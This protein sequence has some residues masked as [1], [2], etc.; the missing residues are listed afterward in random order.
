MTF[1]HNRSLKIRTDIVK[2]LRNQKLSKKCGVTGLILEIERPLVTGILL[3]LNCVCFNKHLLE[4]KKQYNHLHKW[5]NLLCDILKNILGTRKPVKFLWNYL[6]T[7]IF[8][9]KSGK[10]MLFY[11]LGMFRTQ[12]FLDFFSE[13]SLNVTQVKFE[14]KFEGH[15]TTF[16]AI[17][18]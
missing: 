13:F 7:S 11:I 3:F 15:R 4:I 17:H 1:W 10:K 9:K 8:G 2:C 5:R 16:P 6:E 12:R 14:K 18:V